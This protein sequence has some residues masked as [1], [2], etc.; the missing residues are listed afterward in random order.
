MW[1]LN[2]YRNLNKR[3]ISKVQKLSRRP[4]WIKGKLLSHP[5]VP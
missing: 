3:D 1:N 4:S 5:K 2:L